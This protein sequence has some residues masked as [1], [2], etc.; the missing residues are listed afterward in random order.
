VEPRDVRKVHMAAGIGYSLGPL[1]PDQINCVH[2]MP[3]SVLA[4]AAAGLVDLNLLARQELA[5][6]GYDQRGIWVGYKTALAGYAAYLNAYDHSRRPERNH[7]Q[8]DNN[9]AGRVGCA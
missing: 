7:D 3:L 2:A 5:N 4:A 9:A 8:N 1:T 6:R